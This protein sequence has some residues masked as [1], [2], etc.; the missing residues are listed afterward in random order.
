VNLYNASGQVTSQTDPMG[1]VT[2]LSYSG[3]D[4]ATGTGTVNVTDPTGIRPSTTTSSASSALSLNG[5]APVGSTLTSNSSYGPNLTISGSTGGTLL[6]AWSA[7]GDVTSSGIP[8]ETSYTYDFVGEPDLA[9]RPSRR[10]VDETGRLRSTSRAVT[11]RPRPRRTARQPRRA[12]AGLAGRHDHA[13][14][15]APPNGVTYTL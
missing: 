6:D 4:T 8:E 3:L 14:T 11:G 9:G 2:T 13:P 12:C 1:F 5:P 7:N 15:S 10:D